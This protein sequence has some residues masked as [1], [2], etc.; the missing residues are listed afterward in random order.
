M[1]AASSFAVASLTAAGTA[2]GTVQPKVTGA[3]VEVTTEAGGIAAL[4]S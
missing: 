3:M 1:L 2:A 4:A